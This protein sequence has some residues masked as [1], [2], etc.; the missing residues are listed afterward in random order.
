MVATFCV[1]GK[2]AGIK[3]LYFSCPRMAHR[4]DAEWLGLRRNTGRYHV[5]QHLFRFR[6]S[7]ISDRAESNEEECR[8]GCNGLSLTSFW[9][10][11]QPNELSS[12]DL[13]LF[14][15]SNVTIHG[16]SLSLH[17]LGMACR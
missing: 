7:L 10:F 1:S 17:Q 16:G 11:G 4:S 14:G 2:R 9:T 15:F 6:K 8:F 12:C 13:F 3:G 5:F